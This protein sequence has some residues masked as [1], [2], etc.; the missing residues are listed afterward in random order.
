[1]AFGGSDGGA[2]FKIIAQ[3]HQYHGVK[4]AVQRAVDALTAPQG[5][6]GRR[7]LVHPGLGQ[8]AAG[9]VLRDGAARSVGVR[10]PD[11]GAW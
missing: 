11:R 6:Q 1:V 4:K 7:H 2:S 3:W 5:W 8:V 9:P 10:Q